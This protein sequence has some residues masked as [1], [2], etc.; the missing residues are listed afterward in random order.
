MRYAIYFTPPADHA[1]TKTAARWL[2]RDAF[3]GRDHAIQ[4]AGAFSAD[5]LAAL[6]A[7]PRRYGFHATLKAPFALRDGLSEAQLLAAFV[8]LAG[9]FRPFRIPEITLGRLGPFFA[10]VPGGFV[11]ELEMLADACVSQLDSYRAPLSEADFARRKPETLSD[12]QRSNL[13]S[14]G[15]PYV[16]EEFRFHMTLAGPV[17]A[18][19]TDV[20]AACLTERLSAFIG[21]P[22]DIDHLALFVEPERGAPFSVLSTQP[23]QSQNDRKTA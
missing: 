4:P 22:L 13:L 14:W 1:L 3:D 21:Q 10:L 12:S 8:A 18:D 9:S 6:T 7:D 2:G 15:Y 5:E 23:L 16:F 17:P 20:M 19:R 11:P